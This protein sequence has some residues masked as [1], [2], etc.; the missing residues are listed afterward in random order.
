M[1]S[2]NNWALRAWTFVLRNGIPRC[3]TSCHIAKFCIRLTSSWSRPDLPDLISPR[4]RIPAPDPIP[5]AF[6]NPGTHRTTTRPYL[7]TST[8]STIHHSTA[9][10]RKCHVAPDFVRRSKVLPRQENRHP[11]SIVQIHCSGVIP[12]LVYS[13]IRFLVFV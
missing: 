12:S 6:N 3:V 1:W 10:L 5:C 9:R 7:R 11:Y 2:I 4:A 8:H 13:W